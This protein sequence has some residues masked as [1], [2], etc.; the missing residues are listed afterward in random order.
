MTMRGPLSAVRTRLRRAKVPQLAS[1]GSN[2]VI[3]HGCRF[4]EP[5]KISVA[6]DVYIGFEGLFFGFGGINIGRGT[7]LAH[8]VE[9][10]TRNH[11]YDSPD[12]RAIPYDERYI[13]DPVT[14]G[15]YVWVGANVQIVPGVTIGDGAVVAMGSVVTKDVPPCAVVGGNPARVIKER[16]SARF[17]ELRR[18]GRSYFALKAAGQF[19]TVGRPDGHP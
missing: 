2:V 6:D 18:Q 10:M 11:N 1:R 17:D 15:E 4:Y 19:K 14:L 5:G 16:D 3:E 12:L 7:I 13:L 9:I 8:R